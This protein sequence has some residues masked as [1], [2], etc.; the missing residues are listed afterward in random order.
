MDTNK[1]STSLTPTLPQIRQ[2][3]EH[4]FDWRY[5]VKRFDA[6]KKISPENWSTLQRSLQMSASSY[7]LQPWKFIWVQTP[8]LLAEL[9][10][11][12]WGQGQVT[13]CSHFIVFASLKTV[14]APYVQS[15]ISK[16]AKTRDVPV[17]KLKGYQDIIVK[18][19]V[20]GQQ[21]LDVHAW[22]QRQAYIAMGTLLTTAGLL[23][24]D[25]T[26]MEG[27]EPAKYDQILGFAQHPDL[28]DYATVAAVALGYRHAEDPY[29]FAKK[30]RF[31][32]NEVILKK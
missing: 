24:V 18:N 1:D 31:D 11:V 21:G 5:A 12:S 14:T 4:S 6:S 20:E 29:Q 8:S 10:E 28:K 26:P 15:A 16:M 2:A 23:Q 9:R 30:F 3:L 27:L 25:A 13:D 17:E 7:G 19:V 32:L 22:T